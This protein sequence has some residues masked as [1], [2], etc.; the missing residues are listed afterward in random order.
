MILK[1][2]QHLATRYDQSSVVCILADSVCFKKYVHIVELC[3]EL[4]ST[5][6]RTEIILLHNFIEPNIDV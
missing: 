5:F 4:S 3:T 1:I 6:A 2:S